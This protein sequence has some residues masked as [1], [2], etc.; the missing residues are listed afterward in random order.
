LYKVRLKLKIYLISKTMAEV[1]QNEECDSLFTNDETHVQLGEDVTELD[2]THPIASQP[3]GSALQL[4]RHQLTLLQKCLDFEYK[5][6]PVKGK[7]NT[8]ESYMRS[9]IGIIGD[10]VG[11][12]KSFVVLSLVLNGKEDESDNTRVSKNNLNVRSFG[13]NLLTFFDIQTKQ[14]IKTN[15]LIIPHNLCAQWTDY[16]V[17]FCPNIRHIVVS[18]TKTLTTLLDSDISWYDLIVITCTFHNRF[19]S[20]LKHKSI[21]VRRVF[22]DEVDNINIPA[23]ECIESD[24]YWFVTASYNNLVHP[25]GFS[26]YDRAI[27]GYIVTAV[28]LRKSGFIKDLFFDLVSN[29]S[30]IKML[31]VKNSESYINSSIQLPEMIVKYIRCRTPNA[32]TILNGI[33]DRNVIDCLNAGDIESAIQYINPQQRKSED[34]IINLLIEKFEKQ[35]MNI[36]TSLQF[37]HRYV[38]DS[39]EERTTKIGKLQK[40]RKDIMD[41]IDNIKTRIKEGETCCI[42]YDNIDRKTIVS[43]C[44]NAF[45]FKCLNIWLSRYN[46]C[47]LCKNTLTPNN[48]FVVSEKEGQMYSY[49]ETD[50]EMDVPNQ[51]HET[52]DKFKNLKNLLSKLENN[53]DS[54]ILIFSAYDNSFFQVALT[55]QGLNIKY[56]HLKGNNHHIKNTVDAY[57]QGKIKVL[58]VNTVYYG[59]GLNLENTTDIIMFHKFNTECEK[60]VIGRAQRYGR[61]SN[62]KIWYLLHANEMESV[63]SVSAS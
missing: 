43:C 8:V 23:C 14:S 63:R 20:F 34:N 47:P 45:C 17:R 50:M 10:K 62:L 9:K 58:L 1:V 4:K 57:K 3:V 51:I 2:V 5:Q 13:K 54:Q 33:V 15:V 59:S 41:R 46:S 18:K 55:L 12:G 61:T 28:G 32:I 30:L 25:H 36:D 31:V 53:V 7:N 49:G 21:K 6:I 27:Q 38:Y 37:V 48:M 40:E 16:I 52:N 11:S 19:S 56:A 24:F 60:Q 35:L 42:C 29:N 44:S 22:F 26:I 39:E